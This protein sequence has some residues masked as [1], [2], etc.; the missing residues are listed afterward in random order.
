MTA[1]HAHIDLA[2][3][4]GFVSV[5]I[6]TTPDPARKPPMIVRRDELSA[7]LLMLLDAANRAEVD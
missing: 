5:R 4:H 2:D 6:S 7:V 1:I 3:E